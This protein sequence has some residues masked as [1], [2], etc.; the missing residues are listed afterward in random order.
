MK[1]RSFYKKLLEYIYYY[2]ASLRYRG[3][4]KKFKNYTMIPRF[5][6]CANLDL[7]KNFSAIP[8]SVVECGTW[9]G[10]MIGGIAYMLGPD[11]NYMLFDSFEGLPDAKEI[12]GESALR[13]QSDKT[14]PG[15]YDNCTASEQSAH[16]AMKIAGATNVSIIKGWFNNTLR[17]THFQDEIAILRMDADWYDSTLEIFNVLFPKVKKGGII[18]IDDYYTWDGC[19]KA[20]H[21]YLSMNKRE[22]RIYTYRCGVCYIIKR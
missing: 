16:E 2:L 19:S 7:C 15:Y 4:Y 1:Y 22:E 20:V 10:G 6:Y 9:K 21:D 12:D 13:W 17:K 14:S 18:I 3:I 8:G 5:M 11:R